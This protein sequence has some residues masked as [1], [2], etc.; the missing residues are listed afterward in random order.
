MTSST[1]DS[2]FIAQSWDSMVQGFSKP[3]TAVGERHMR[4]KAYVIKGICNLRDSVFR[5]EGSGFRVQGSGFRVQGS[6]FRFRVQGSGSRVQGSGVRVQGSGFRVRG[7]GPAATCSTALKDAVVVSNSTMSLNDPLVIRPRISLP[8]DLFQ[9]RKSE[10]ARHS[11]GGS[12][13][14]PQP[15]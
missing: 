1:R 6:G 8:Q 4:S 15:A 14:T 5:V 10:L 2:W 13:L 7:L 9:K 11:V 12:R 3:S